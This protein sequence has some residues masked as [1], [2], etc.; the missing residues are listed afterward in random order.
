MLILRGQTG[1]SFSASCRRHPALDAAA[2]FT[3]QQKQWLSKVCS[4]MLMW[5]LDA[6]AADEAMLEFLHAGMKKG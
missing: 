4:Q 3:G 6:A 2:R 1:F 5:L